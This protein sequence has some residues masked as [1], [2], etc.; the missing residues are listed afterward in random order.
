MGLAIAGHRHHDPRRLRQRGL[1]LLELD[2]EILDTKIDNVDDEIVIA[3]LMGKRTIGVIKGGATQ[4]DLP[5]SRPDVEAAR[6]RLLPRGCHAPADY[7]GPRQTRPDEPLM[8]PRVVIAGSREVEVSREVA[9]G[10]ESP[11]SHF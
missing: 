7:A 8:Q 3:K 11:R 4:P 9:S 10:F 2:L 1:H 5:T 6:P